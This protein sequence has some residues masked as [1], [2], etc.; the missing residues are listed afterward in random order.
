MNISF[1]V[2]SPETWVNGEFEW[3]AKVFYFVPL[4][5]L[6]GTPTKV[7]E[8]VQRIRA[9]VETKG[10][11]VPEDG[12]L[13]MEPGFLKGKLLLEIKRPKEYDANTV[14]HDK[15]KVF[16]IVHEGPVKTSKESVKK[17]TEKIKS[18]KGMAPTRT[19]LWDFRHGPNLEGQRIKRTVIICQI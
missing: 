4:P 1:D 16:S 6:F 17:L 8:T 5:C 13:L 18:D 14:E 11:E 3:G 2:N 9:E 15:A 12:M 10:F 7:F 19:L